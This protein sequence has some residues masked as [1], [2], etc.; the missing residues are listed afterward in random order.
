[1]VVAGIPVKASKIQQ[2]GRQEKCWESWVDS[3]WKKLT[4]RDGEK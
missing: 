3:T 2:A 4:A 1:M